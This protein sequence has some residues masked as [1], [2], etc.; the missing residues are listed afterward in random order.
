MWFLRLLNFQFFGYFCESI[1]QRVGRQRNQY[2]KKTWAATNLLLTE[3][4]LSEYQKILKHLFHQSWW[5]KVWSFRRFLLPIPRY[6]PN[7]KQ[8]L[9]TNRSCYCTVVWF[10]SQTS[11]NWHWGSSKSVLV[12]QSLNTPCVDFQVT[13]QELSRL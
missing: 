6:C 11:K 1:F 5:E 8:A 3:D 13:K 2:R 4:L 10:S 7:V 12:V 9:W